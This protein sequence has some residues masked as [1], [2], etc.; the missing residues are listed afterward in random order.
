[1]RANTNLWEET[2]LI[3]A[4]NAKSWEDVLYVT[5]DHFN[6]SKENFEMVAKQTEYYQ[7]Y[8]AAEVATDLKL[9]GKD[10]WVERGEYDGSEWWDFKIPPSLK[11]ETKEVTRLTGRK[12]TNL[13]QTNMTDEELDA[14]D[15]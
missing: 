9:V 12:W 15:E 1:M 11:A 2:Q 6:I 5:A 14:E 4:D 8:G 10:F 13:K 7:G 3:L